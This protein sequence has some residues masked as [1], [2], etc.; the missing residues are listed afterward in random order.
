MGAT[1][2]QE[3]GRT[4][5]AGI[6]AD[7]I[8]V[9]PGVYDALSGRLA[10]RAGFETV[11][12]S[13]FSISAT[14]LG[15]PD[16]GLLTMSENVEQVRSIVAG[17]SVP[18]VADLDT[19]YGN[20]LNVRRTVEAAMDAGVAG[21]ILE[22]Q[23]WPKRCGHME[24]KRVIDAEEHASRIRAAADVRAERDRD[25]VIIGRTDAREPQGLSAALER[26]HRYHEAGA[27]VIFVE[28]PQSREELETVADE[29]D[30]PVFANMIEGGQTPY[31]PASELE[32]IGF[33]IV[34][35]P[36]SGLFAATRALQEAYGALAAEGT[37]EGVDAASFDEFEQVID[38]AS[39]RRREQE[40]ADGGGGE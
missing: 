4:L 15:K 13:G 5:R 28:A 30:A 9:M 34:V 29:F 6:D 26:G 12:T 27:D 31:L 25:F 17:L 16:M 20:A 1:R 8:A 33:D 7:E 2:E 22:D 24:E 35:Y 14:Q 21:G 36:L 39:F 18:L 11:F 38:A 23:A 19:G 37:A 32:A 3:P 10:E 40:Y